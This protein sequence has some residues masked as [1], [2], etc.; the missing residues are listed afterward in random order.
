MMSMSPEAGFV[1]NLPSA[2]DS[3]PGIED[4]E[5]DDRWDGFDADYEGDSD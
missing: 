1:K 4:D 2:C 3:Q 5:E